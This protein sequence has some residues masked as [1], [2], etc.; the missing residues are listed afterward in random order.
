MI[1]WKTILNHAIV[2]WRICL[3][4]ETSI[5]QQS[6]PLISVS[7]A[8]DYFPIKNDEFITPFEFPEIS[9]STRDMQ[10]EFPDDIQCLRNSLNNFSANL[11]L[12]EHSFSKM[13]DYYEKP[14]TSCMSEHADLSIKSVPNPEDNSEI[15]LTNYNGEGYTDLS[16]KSIPISEVTSDIPAN[17]TNFQGFEIPVKDTNF[18]F[19]KLYSGGECMSGCAESISEAFKI[20]ESSTRSFVDQPETGELLCQ[21]Y[22]YN[23]EMRI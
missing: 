12:N 11:G 6:E 22:L 17:I 7:S 20:A 15:P 19:N 10:H 8:T 9:S 21:N 5:L 23:C 16:T 2:L 18:P 14:S 13:E 4:P 1:L 3:K